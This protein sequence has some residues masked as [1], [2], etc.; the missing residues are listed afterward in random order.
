MPNES[1]PLIETLKVKGKKAMEQLASQE[2][3]KN[4]KELASTS[5]EKLK[6]Q[7]RKANVGDT[8]IRTLAVIGGIA[9]VVT[10]LHGVAG[11]IFSLNPIS[12][13]MDIITASFGAL[14]IVFELD[15]QYLP[16]S[17]QIQGFVSANFPFLECVTGRGALYIFAGL[18]KMSQVCNTRSFSVKIFFLDF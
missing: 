16:E 6:E 8:S 3:K 17:L 12:G 7:G 13:L 2:T 14:A 1:T 9:M 5:I 10:S 11:H 4:A 15:K 18:L